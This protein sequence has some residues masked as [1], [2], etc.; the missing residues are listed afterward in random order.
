M[1]KD[2]KIME[3]FSVGFELFKKN[4]W[5]VLGVSVVFLIFEFS[6][7][8][9]MKFFEGYSSLINFLVTILLIIVAFLLNVWIIKFFLMVYENKTFSTKEILEK[10]NRF[11]PLLLYSFAS[12]F[13]FIGSFIPFIIPGIIIS[14]AL[15]FTAFILIDKKISVKDAIQTSYTITYGYKWDIFVFLLLLFI[16]NF[17]GLLFF[18]IG[19]LVTFPIT[20]L[21]TIDLYR[22]LLK[23]ATDEGRLPVQKKTAWPT[24]FFWLGFIISILSVIG[25]VYL[26]T[27]TIFY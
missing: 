17:F 5:A 4:F 11:W 1:K 27:N 10:S 26:I 12:F 13:I 14:L 24:I 6:N 8:P 20:F 15:Y 2:I 3:S 18:V 21:A 7:S 23:N 16:F 22:R 19:L 9:V 25:I